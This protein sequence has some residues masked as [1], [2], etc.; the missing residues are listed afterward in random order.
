MAS[1]TQFRDI[2]EPR[3]AVVLVGAVVRA[4]SVG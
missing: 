1:V 4:V 2:G 3:K